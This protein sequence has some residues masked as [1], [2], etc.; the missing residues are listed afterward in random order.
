MTCTVNVKQDFG[1]KEIWNFIIQK[2]TLLNLIFEARMCSN[3]Y[4]DFERLN[5]KIFLVKCLNKR[6]TFSR[7]Y[8]R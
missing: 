4:A 6:D 1:L 5:H 7:K 8:D 3:F 2:K